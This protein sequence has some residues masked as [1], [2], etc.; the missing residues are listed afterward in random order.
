M[1]KY[2]KI[3]TVYKRDPDTKYKTLLEGQYSEPEFEYLAN[4]PWLFTEKVDGTNVR[5][6]WDGHSVR[7]GGRTNNAQ[8]PAFMLERL[9]ELFPAAKMEKQFDGEVTLFGEGYGARIQKGGG[10]YKSDGVDL[11]LFDVYCGMWLRRNSVVEIGDSL[12]IGVVPIIASGPLSKA[13]DMARE[14]FESQWGPFP[15]EGLVMRPEVDLLNRRGERV[16][17]KIKHK[18]FLE[19][20]E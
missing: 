9:M 17:T 19:V 12:G 3:Q 8:L 11:V 13:V 20:E 14:G 7:F 15:A 2:P 16:I 4:L 5:V 1:L 6:H 18:D 10:N